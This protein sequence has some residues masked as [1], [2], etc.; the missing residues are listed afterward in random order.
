MP[1]PKNA[2]EIFQLLE[3]SNCRDCG[4]KTC[5]AFAGAVFRG[6]S[7]IDECS[8]LDRKTIEQYSGKSEPQNAIEENR[9]EYINQLK[10]EMSQ[11]DLDEAAQR[12][13]GR[14]SDNKLTLKVLGKN[15][16][17]DSKGNLYTDI[18]INPWIALPFLTYVL[19]GKGLPVSGNW[20][21]FR[22][23]K[24]GMD[25]YPLFQKRCEEPMKRVADTYTDLFD[26]MAHIFSGKQVEKQFESDISVVL[27]PLPKV[28]IMVCYWLPEDGLESS[29]HVFFDQTADDNLGTGIVFTI[30]AGLS[31]M[32][33]KLAIRHGS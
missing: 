18:H 29:L 33:A 3:K 5:L 22:E 16:S 31:Q 1:Q 13:G 26:D 8:K 25:G 28:P 12:T 17:V 21:S 19:H 4:Q 32:F 9:E 23:L 7:R 24:D 2:M 14:V 27:H 30:G 10:A 20:V 6:Q 15:F 11:L